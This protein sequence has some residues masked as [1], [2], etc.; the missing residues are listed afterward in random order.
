MD[1]LLLFFLIIEFIIDFWV[2]FSSHTHIF[3]LNY[4]KPK[5]QFTWIK[6]NIK[7]IGTSCTI[8]I[9]IFLLLLLGEN[10]GKICA[11]I[12]Y[13]IHIYMYLPKE[14]KIPLVYTNR[15]LRLIG[16]AYLIIGCTMLGVKRIE[17]LPIFGLIVPGLLLVI[18]LINKPINLY[19]N[20]QYINQAKKTIKNMPNLIVIG[21]TGSYGKTSVKNFLG[22]LLSTKYNVLITPENYNTTLGVTKTIREKLRPIHQIFICEM[23]ATKTGDIKEICDLVEPQHGIIT[24]IGPQ[25]LE[26]FLNIENV[27]KTKFEL[28]NSLPKD[29]MV[30][31][32]YDNT[33]IKEHKIE[34][35]TISYG[36]EN[37]NVDYLA[38]NICTN[39]KGLTFKMKDAEKNEYTFETKILGQH[40]ITN[41]AG[42]IAIANKL[43]I[44]MNKLVAKVKSLEGVEHRLQLRES[45]KDLIIDDAYNSNPN[46]AKSALDTLNLFSGVKIVITPG[47]IEL[48]EKQYECNNTFG[49]QIAEIADYI[50]LVGEKQTKPIYEGIASKNFNKENI[51]IV[52]D[53]KKAITIANNLQ[54]EERKI[55]LLENDLPDNY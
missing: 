33:Y 30:F 4:Y 14:A 27:I 41:I 15:V 42:C 17:L 24:S 3:Q 49:K 46:G 48:G 19:I 7:T 54:T 31:L 47:M 11:I 44:P 38:Y 34:K 51:I 35:E 20:K 10:I 40:N 26:S 23:G 55:I 25:H 32:N 22:K 13:L 1:F 53:V 12:I 29:G 37:K 9:G 52:E 28:S 36:A 18:D 39:Q 21:V 8:Y 2:Y 5:Q 16:T 6:K 45:G 50:I 43:G